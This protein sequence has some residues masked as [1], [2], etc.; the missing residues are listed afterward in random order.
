MQ[1]ILTIK[2][3]LK[4]LNDEVEKNPKALDYQLAREDY[5]DF[6]IGYCNFIFG[7]NRAKVVKLPKD[8]KKKDL[9]V[10]CDLTTKKILLI[11]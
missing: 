8:S 9:G 3:L 7:I 6:S 4:I 11:N 10:D 5:D 1:D 2:D